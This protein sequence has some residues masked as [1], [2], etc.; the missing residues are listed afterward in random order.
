MKGKIGHIVVMVGL[1]A[2]LNS[3]SLAQGPAWSGGLS[4]Q[5]GFLWAHTPALGPLDQTPWQGLLVDFRPP[6]WQT[7][8]LNNSLPGCQSGLNLLLLESERDRVLGKKLAL[9]LFVEPRLVG[10]W[11]LR[12][13]AGAAYSTRYYA[14]SEDRL[15]QGIS[16]PVNAWLQAQ[17]LYERALG[18]QWKA[19][20][21]LGLHHFSNGNISLPNYGLNMPA[22]S[23]GVAWHPLEGGTQPGILPEEQKPETHVWTEGGL[24]RVQPFDRSGRVLHQGRLAVYAL[25]TTRSVASAWQVGAEA[26]FNPAVRTHP[27]Y[28]TDQIRFDRYALTAGHHWT[29]GRLSLATLAGVYL[30]QAAPTDGPWYQRYTV[31]YTPRSQRWRA[32]ISLKSHYG[33]AEC[34]DANIALRLY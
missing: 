4:Y 3:P 30:W 18:P 12:I 34:L 29:M 22:L 8:V 14:L 6:T 20:V 11:R 9:G 7:P 1:W 28:P 31:Y 21:G 26:L 33:R 32:G 13:G 15:N 27:D 5:S 25:R 16:A 10:G 2:G 19:R 24:G 23:V 17:L